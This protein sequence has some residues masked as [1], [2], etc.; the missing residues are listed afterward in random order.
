[1][2]IVNLSLGR[3]QIILF[4]LHPHFYHPTYDQIHYFYFKFAVEWNL[5]E[6]Q[7]LVPVSFNHFGRNAQKLPILLE[8]Y[9]YHVSA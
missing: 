7:M 3:E 2:G 4:K 5:N 8:Q 6:V 9:V 1:M